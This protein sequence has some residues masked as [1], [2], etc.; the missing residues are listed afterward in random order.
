MP[1]SL[2]TPPTRL[3]ARAFLIVALA[4]AVALPA[5]AHAQT[6]APD[7]T[8]QAARAVS[9]PYDITVVTRVKTPTA[10]LGTRFTVR[11]LSAA[12]QKTLDGDLDIIYVGVRPDGT[13]AGRVE[14]PQLRAF[15]EFYEY[16][17]TL[18][19]PGTWRYTIAVESIHGVGTVDGAVTVLASVDSGAGGVA[20]WFAVIVILIVGAYLLYR[21]NKKRPQD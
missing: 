16:P 14:F 21:T 12:T 20:I 5:L 15:P 2:R 8:N 9:G 7:L 17:I 3:L 18:D 19:R 1:A 4:C 13:E 10:G 11:V 6:Q